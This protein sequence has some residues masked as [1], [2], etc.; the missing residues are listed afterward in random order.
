[1]IRR[2]LLATLS[3]LL[4]SAFSFLTWP[5]ADYKRWQP[6]AEYLAQVATYEVPEFPADWRTTLYTTTDGTRLR[7]GETSNRDTAKATLVIV[8]GYTATLDMYGEHVGLLRQRGYHVMAVDLR[9]QGMSERARPDKPEKLFVKDFG[10]YSDDLAGFISENAPQGAKV[11]PFGM[12]LG[13]HV[14][15]RMAADHPGTA[16]ALF[17]LAPAIEPNT[18]GVDANLM[19]RV[20][21]LAESLG[22]GKRYLPGQGDWTPKGRDFSIA[23]PEFCASE[24]KRLWLRDVIYTR[25]PQQRV[26]GVTASWGKGLMDSSKRLRSSDAVRSLPLPVTMFRAEVEDFVE[27]DAMEAVCG[28][29][30]NC[31]LIDLPG[32]A[33]CLMQESDS[34]IE[35]MFDQ[36]DA[37]VDANGLARESDGQRG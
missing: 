20:A 6:D 7:W 16:D 36:L 18:G 8:P 15:L 17:L 24:P 9:G 21:S 30:P 33:H 31:R 1:M 14:A 25:M 22:R 27:N 23:A 13:G 12:S 5:E 4:L 34:V 10:V 26:G 3:L 37:M 28:A 32:T 2:A 19:Y 29:M 35:Q 11:I